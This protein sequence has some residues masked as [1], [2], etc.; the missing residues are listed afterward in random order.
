MKVQPTRLAAAAAKLVGWTFIHPS[1]LQDS[2]NQVIELWQGSPKQ[3]QQAYSSVHRAYHQK[4]LQDR[5]R[6]K[7]GNLHG[8]SELLEQ[9][10]NLLPARRA[11]E[12]KYTPQHIK[13]GL[14]ALALGHIN[15]GSDHVRRGTLTDAP[16]TLCG[17]LRDDFYHRVIECQGDE[18]IAAR[19][20]LPAAWYK[21]VQ[22]AGR[23]HILGNAYVIPHV[24]G[25]CKVNQWHPV[26]HSWTEDGSNDN[27]DD[28]PFDFLPNMPVYTD[29]SCF[30]GTD[31]VLAAAGAA[32][33]QVYP[34]G[35]PARA[36]WVTLPAWLPQTAA[37]AEHTTVSLA[38]NINP[39]RSLHIMSDCASVV[40]SAKDREWER[41]QRV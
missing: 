30:C 6:N 3:L 38:V 40:A 4:Q 24:E 31:P 18:A 11:L 32:A 14:R 41:P 28:V 17:N 10:I 34:N 33:V 29:G 1:A 12:S 21:Q 27:D 23:N 25:I 22:K 5:I 35:K 37:S 8:S 7:W 39:L 2:H 13:P 19:A 26:Y 9:G 15:T 36:A 16:C 20:Y